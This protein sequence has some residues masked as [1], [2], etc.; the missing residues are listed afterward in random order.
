M[1]AS[2]NCYQPSR[3][4]YIG[5]DWGHMCL[6][7]MAT[8]DHFRLGSCLVTPEYTTRISLKLLNYYIYRI[9]DSFK[10]FLGL[11]LSSPPSI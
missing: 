2:F 5:R 9:D 10:D 8:Y 4:D 6:G 7:V 3:L 1:L 11:R